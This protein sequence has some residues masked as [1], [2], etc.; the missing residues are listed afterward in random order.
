ML[1]PK[2][3]EGVPVRWI[4]VAAPW[5]AEVGGDARGTRLQ[6]TA[7]ARITMRFDDESADLVHDEEYEVVVTPLTELLDLTRAAVAVDH[8]ERDL[9]TEAPAG[10]SYVLPEAKISTKAFWTKLQRDLLDQI[11]R[12]RQL[13]LA[14]NKQLKLVAR[15]G[16]TFEAFEA[17]CL[18]AADERADAEIAKLKDTYETRFRRLRDQLDTAEDRVDV[19]REE[20]EGKRNEELLST[21]GGVLGGIFGGRRRGG[22]LGSLNK[23]ASKRRQSSTAG[24]RLDAAEDKVQTISDQLIELQGDL[25]NEV[26]RIDVRWA[27]LAKEITTVQ[28]P[29]E[30]GDV[31]LT[32]LVL[33]WMPVA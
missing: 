1:A 21:V 7:V 4:D 31:K 24:A 16:E 26:T 9:R 15:P 32:Q 17:R 23:A 30:K 14:A 12:S 22:A 3:A 2:V 28:I 19:L 11:V 27:T 6:A 29:L 33:G 13:E 10:I 5:L 20:R 25:E 8:D 18:A